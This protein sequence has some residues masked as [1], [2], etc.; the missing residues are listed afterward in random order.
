MPRKR[1]RISPRDI[2]SKTP[3]D[4]HRRFV[5]RYMWLEPEVDAT[6]RRLAQEDGISCTDWVRRAIA[7]RASRRASEAKDYVR[8]VVPE[9]VAR[10]AERELTDKAEFLLTLARRHAH[11]DPSYAHRLR[12]EGDVLLQ[13]A[14][15]FAEVVS[16]YEKLPPSGV[17]N[18]AGRPT[19]PAA[20]PRP[21]GSSPTPAA[22]A[23]R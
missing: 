14:G 3:A 12:Q 13:R 15:W 17:P 22:P 20:P 11:Q 2:P 4:S 7:L 8:R 6:L 10:A 9:A 16:D 1:L 18:T 23:S 19:R 5:S 21:A